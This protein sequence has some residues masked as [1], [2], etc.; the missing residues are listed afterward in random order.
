M[1][2][3]ASPNTRSI[4]SPTYYRGVSLLQKKC[5]LKFTS[6][7]LSCHADVVTPN[8]YDVSPNRMLKS[9][10]LPWHNEG[11]NVNWWTFLGVVFFVVLVNR[12][13]PLKSSFALSM[14]AAAVW[15]LLL[16]FVERQVSKRR[17]LNSS[18]SQ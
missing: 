16:G 17:K 15:G 11:A 14:V 1:Y 6:G 3:P 7:H 9:V 12:I 4:G 2:S 13:G 18:K 8:A 10:I 5:P